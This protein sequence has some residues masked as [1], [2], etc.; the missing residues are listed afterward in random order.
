[1]T[2]NQDSQLLLGQLQE[3][4]REGADGE[5]FEI[6]VLAGLLAR[7]GAEDPAARA[8]LAV[9][10]GHRDEGTLA[11]AFPTEDQLDEAAERLTALD[12]DTDAAEHADALWELDELCAGAWFCGRGAELADTV[13]LAART[14]VAF[15][16]PFQGLAEL[17]SAVL[18]KVPPLPGDPA[19]RL[20]RAVEATA[21]LGA[22]DHRLDS[23]PLCLSARRRL[24]L[25]PSASL[26]GVPERAPL[27]ATSLP[28][29]PPL[30]VLLQEDAVEVA[31]GVD[32]E[33][34]AL[35]IQVREGQDGERPTPRL[36]RD[37]EEV[38]LRDLSAG[39]WCGAAQV[40]VHQLHLAGQTHQ[41]ELTA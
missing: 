25:W 32:G 39:L 31:L 6:A 17:A 2:R 41:L 40:G 20:W 8:A 35:F 3:A 18:A 13:D 19:L 30:E 14:V 1:M 4:L 37:G 28:G 12:E 36:Q 9:A 22:D 38:P 11:A 5:P 24:G 29:A 21:L 10:R 27:R 16:A 34:R 33:A 23:V 26:R 7:T 15:P